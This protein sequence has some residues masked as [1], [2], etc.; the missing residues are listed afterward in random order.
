MSLSIDIAFVTRL[1]PYLKLFKHVG[2]YNYACR[3]PFC[4]DS[5]KSAS[6]RRGGFFRGK[7]DT[8]DM[9]LFA[10]FNCGVST[11][12]GKVIQ[13]CSVDLYDEYKFAQYRENA[14]I[15][16]D[17]EVE[18]SL[19]IFKASSRKLNTTYDAALDDIF[20]LDVLSENHPAVKYIASRAIPRDKW[21]LFY[22]APKFMTWTNTLVPNKFEMR[23]ADYPRL[24][25]PSFNEHGKMFGFAARAFGD[26][27]PKYYN[28]KLDEDEEKIYG[29]ER[30]DYAKPVIIVEGQLDSICIPNTIAVAG[31]SFDTPFVRGIKT[32]CVLVYDREPRNN[33]LVKNIKK[34]IDAGY[35][36]CLLPETFPGKD[37]NEAIIAGMTQQEI[38]KIINDNTFVGIDAQI[39]FAQWNKCDQQKSKR[40]YFDKNNINEINT[41]NALKAHILR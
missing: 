20:C 25:I 17:D 40:T 21:H 5:K 12:I 34:T 38:V 30:L 33:E 7:D 2:G 11:T 36:V 8:S 23:T 32:N 13:H 19:D 18:V 1:R 31:S 15:D 29:R 4:G 16:D 39:K 14:P 41:L 35:R 9:L 6:K 22:F 37:I 24:I 28:V 27:T 10:C 3:C 26:E